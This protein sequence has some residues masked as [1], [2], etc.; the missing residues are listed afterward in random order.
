MKRTVLFLLLT[1]LVG[2]SIAQVEREGEKEKDEKKEHKFKKENLSLGGDI[3]VSFYSGGTV[4]G[5][6]PYLAYSLNKYVDVAANINFNYTSQRDNYVYGDK[7]RQT[8][9]GPGAF[10]RLYPVHFL[11]AQVQYEHNFI[12]Q[13]YIPASNSGYA[14]DKI[15]FDANSVLVGG[16]Y[17]TG[18]RDGGNTFYYFSVLWDVSKVA[19]SPYIDAAGRSI[20]IIKAG[21]NIGLFQGKNH[22]RRGRW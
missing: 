8:V 9:F 10:M 15:H 13:K 21:I 12:T 22:K 16:G 11:F 14:A 1:G 2:S 4:L 18:R 19:E 6:S 5:L 3:T 17:T 7:I 20:P